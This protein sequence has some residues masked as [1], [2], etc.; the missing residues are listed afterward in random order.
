MRAGTGSSR[1]LYLLAVLAVAFGLGLAAPAVF[2]ASKQ[3]IYGCYNKTGGL[4]EI[5]KGPG[6]CSFSETPISWN[7]SGPKGER[8]PQGERGPRG[9][10]GPRGPEGKPPAFA[11]GR[12]AATVST[13]DASSYQDLGGPTVTVN[14]PASGFVEVGASA[15]MSGQAGAISLFD[16]T[17][18]GN[19]APV[20]GQSDVCD[21][22]SGAP[23]GVGLLFTSPGD[24]FDGTFSTPAVPNILGFCGSSG[25]PSTV[26]LGPLSP[27]EHELQLRYAA[28][29]CGDGPAGQASFKDRRLWVRPAP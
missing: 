29:G 25:G 5:V 16:V 13:S 12:A 24:D 23:D 14:V 8:G 9:Q 28:C 27:G 18:A 26:L 21:D 4:L 3:T 20:P 2:A 10:A 17:D 1:K 6:Q 11:R 22:V 7:R 19:P 15:F